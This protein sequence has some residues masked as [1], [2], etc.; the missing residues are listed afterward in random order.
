MILEA[1][2]RAADADIGFAVAHADGAAAVA[3]VLE[4]T[5]L[6]DELPIHPTRDA[7]VAAAQ[8]ESARG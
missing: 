5:G 3:R 8:P 7:A 2:R 6:R 1:R 4:I